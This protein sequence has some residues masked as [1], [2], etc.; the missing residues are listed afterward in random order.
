M[1]KIQKQRGAVSLL[2]TILILAGILIIALAVSKIMLSEIRISGLAAD[3]IKAY[4]AADSG[5]EWAL[6]Q[7]KIGQIPNL[8]GRLCPDS[9]TMV[10]EETDYCLEIVKV[11]QKGEPATIRTTGRAGKIRRIVETDL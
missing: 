11:N 2:L 7:I 6:Y 1:F 4:Q 10:G 9:W 8:N 3:S 5:L